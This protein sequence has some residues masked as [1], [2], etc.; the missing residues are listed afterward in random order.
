MFHSVIRKSETDFGNTNCLAHKPQSV[1]I[2]NSSNQYSVLPIIE[3]RFTWIPRVLPPWR[4]Q[5]WRMHKFSIT[6]HN[7]RGFC[8]VNF[9]WISLI[10]YLGWSQQTVYFS[11]MVQVTQQATNPH[12]P[13][14]QKTQ[15]SKQTLHFGRCFPNRFSI[16]RES[17]NQRSLSQT[18][19]ECKR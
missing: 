15:S 8:F 16:F 3:K 14:K 18:A 5:T 7:N 11:H 19:N 12:Q 4:H 2:S 10:I 13:S 9:L 1:P 17:Q 6:K